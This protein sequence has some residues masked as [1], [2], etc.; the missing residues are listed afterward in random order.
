MFSQILLAAV[1]S[2]VTGRR[3]DSQRKG[4]L[5]ATNSEV[6]MERSPSL[7]SPPPPPP[8]PPWSRSS[9][10]T[11][12]FFKSRAA[13]QQQKKNNTHTK[14][15]AQRLCIWTDS[16]LRLIRSIFRC[17][18][19][20]RAISGRRSPLF[21]KTRLFSAAF[22]LTVALPANGAIICTTTGI[23]GHSAPTPSHRQ[24][25]HLL[26]PQRLL[27]AVYL[28]GKKSTILCYGNKR[29]CGNAQRSHLISGVA[30]AS[31]QPVIPVRWCWSPPQL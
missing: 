12:Y 28:V 13:Q 8:L 23:E 14:P 29:L 21:I 26:S 4:A 30:T 27:S 18:A 7:Y 31:F 19:L 25:P 20:I 6:G 16:S 2:S 9:P 22:L 17:F 11:I 1:V 5:D 15:T 24:T 10:W 3:G